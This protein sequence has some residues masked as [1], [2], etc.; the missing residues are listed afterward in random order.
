MRLANVLGL[1]GRN[2]EASEA[3]AEAKRIGPPGWNLE[4][5]IRTLRINWRDNSDI[6]HPLTSGLRV[7]EEQ[8]VPFFDPS[9]INA[10]SL[11]AE[12]ALLDKLSARQRAVLSRALKGMLNKVIADELNI[13]EGTVK[14]HLS[15]AFKVLGVK[16]R[17][18]AVYLLSKRN[19]A[20][21]I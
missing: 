13:A 11:S 20:I 9:D 18:E 14:A 21:D 7:I 2:E 1:L 16:N 5:Y 17:T 10:G 15:A 12:G 4:K 3:L 6:L 8:Q 19:T